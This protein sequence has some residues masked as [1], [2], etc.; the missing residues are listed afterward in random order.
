MPFRQSA[1]TDLWPYFFNKIKNFGV[2]RRIKKIPIDFRGKKYCKNCHQIAIERRKSGL[3]KDRLYELNKVLENQKQSVYM[4]LPTVLDS[5][6]Y[7]TVERPYGILLQV[8]KIF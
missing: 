2:F 7:Y 4:E 8:E 6:S 3:S 5:G 1:Q